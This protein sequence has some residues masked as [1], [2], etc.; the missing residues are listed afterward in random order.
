MVKARVPF[1]KVIYEFLE[2]RVGFKDRERV[3]IFLIEFLEFL[4]FL[5][6]L[7]VEERSLL[8]NLP[9]VVLVLVSSIDVLLHDE[10]LDFGEYNY[11]L[12]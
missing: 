7:F 10:E 4:L 5:L 8:L 11:L 6:S 12:I 9:L 1:L 2:L 3:Y